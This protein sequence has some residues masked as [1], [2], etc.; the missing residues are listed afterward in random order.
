MAQKNKSKIG[1]NNF[2]SWGASIVIIG[3]MAKLMHWPWGDWLIIVG[4]GTEALLFFLLGFQNTEEEVVT[5]Q[6]VVSNTNAGA[7]QALDNLLQQGD[8][9]PAMIQRLGDGLRGFHDKIQAISDVSEASLA[10]TQ[11]TSSLKE[12]TLG[13]RRLNESFEKV[14]E[15]IAK[16]GNTSTNTNDYQE[17]INKLSQNLKQLNLVYEEELTASGSKLQGISKEFDK[18]GE[19]FR[20]FNA[21]AEGT[22]QLREQIQELNKSLAALNQVYA[23]MLS[24]MNQS[25]N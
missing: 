3:L 15:D 25:R 6:V 12:A 19:T 10:T 4:L 23:N 17:Q 21:S 9:T 24:A 20:Q 22:N 2:I 14:T 7:T 5:E 1:L 16:I 18:V 13:F 8:I 11:F